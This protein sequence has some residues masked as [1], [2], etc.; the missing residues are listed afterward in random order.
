[1]K[2]GA[3]A[4]L[5]YMTEKTG[6][7]KNLRIDTSDK[8][9]VVQALKTFYSRYLAEDKQDGTAFDDMVIDALESIIGQRNRLIV[10]VCESEHK[11][12]VTRDE[13]FLAVNKLVRFYMEEH[14]M[15]RDEAKEEIRKKCTT[16]TNISPWMKE[17]LTS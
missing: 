2:I 3:L 5:E 8:K 10:A 11:R 13:W 15:T 7:V 1:M 14:G 9:D 4:W 6:K 12:P 17:F 16:S